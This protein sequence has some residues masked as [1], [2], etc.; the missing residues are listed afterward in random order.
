MASRLLGQWMA[1]ERTPKE[2][3]W[4]AAGTATEE[5]CPP[6]REIRSTKE[7]Y[8]AETYRT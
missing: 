1:V 5:D 3:G 6:C 4:W 2:K 7:I 8:H